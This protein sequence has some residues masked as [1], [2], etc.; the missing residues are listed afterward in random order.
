MLRILTT[1]MPLNWYAISS[2][3]AISCVGGACYPEGHVEAANKTEDILHLK[4]KVDAGCEFLTTQMFFDNNIMYKLPVPYREKRGITVSGCCRHY[5]GDECQADSSV[6]LLCPAP[7][8]P[9]A[10]RPSLTVSVT[11]RRL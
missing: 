9:N 1:T 5:A 10:S 2:R 3:R 11:I 4:E 6:S 8:C 7:T